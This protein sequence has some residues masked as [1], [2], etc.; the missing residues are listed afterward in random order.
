L[1]DNWHGKARFTVAVP[2]LGCCT[3]KQAEQ[4]MGNKP[5]RSPPP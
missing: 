5:V 2:S 3:E 4:A 1:I